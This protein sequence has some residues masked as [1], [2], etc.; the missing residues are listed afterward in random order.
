MLLN[1]L[2]GLTVT[3]ELKLTDELTLAEVKGL[4]VAEAG[5]SGALTKDLTYLTAKKW[6]DSVV[7]G[8][9]YTQKFT[10]SNTFSYQKAEVNRQQAKVSWDNAKT[11]LEIRIRYAYHKWDTAFA[12]YQA[13]SKKP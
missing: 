3:T 2:L 5:F 10:S 13:Y 6:Y 7:L 11:D 12:N 9:D 4:N 1:Q 8:S